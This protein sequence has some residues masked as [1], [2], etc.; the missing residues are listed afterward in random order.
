[1][2][3]DSQSKIPVINFSMI[4]SIEVDRGTDKWRHL[5]KMVREAC[6][7]CGC[8]EAIYDKVP[9]QLREDTFSMIKQL[10]SLPL[11]AQKKN[12]NPKPFGG[13]ALVPLYESFGLEDSSNYESVES[14][15][16]SFGEAGLIQNSEGKMRVFKVKDKQNRSD[17]GKAAGR[18]EPKVIETLILDSYGL[19]VGVGEGE[20][21]KR[22]SK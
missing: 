9:R 7:T 16:A 3:S 13:F 14:F 10:F 21:F 15:T 1:M 12:T 11:E 8:F 2:G 18:V 20:K 6:E 19:G 4:S 22:T 17:H 5:C